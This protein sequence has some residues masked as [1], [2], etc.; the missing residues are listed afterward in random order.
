[1]GSDKYSDSTMV[2]QLF[3]RIFPTASLRARHEGAHL[4]VTNTEL[5][6]DLVYVFAIIQL[7]H[8]L[9]AHPT[10]LGALEAVTLFAAI[11]WA[12]NYT[13]WAANW[14]D[15][16][17]PAGRI[18]MLVLMACALLMAIS[19]ESAFEYR[20]WLFVSAYIAMALVRAGYMAGVLRGQTMGRNYAQLGAWSAFS[21]LFWIAG[22]HLPSARIELWILA[23]LIDYAAPYV[24]FWLPGA[25]HTPM[26]T[27]TLRGLHLLERNQL[28]FIIALGESI[29]MLGATM[30]EAELTSAAITAAAT[31]FLTIV[32]V[33]W[34]YFVHSASSGEEA[35]EHEA[36]QTRL[37]RASL[38]YA[39]G[40]M[41]GGAIV[42]A[43]SIEEIIA[44]PLEPA[45]IPTILAA[46][47]GPS[48]FLLGNALF[49]CSTAGR[50]PLSYVLAIAVLAAIGLAAHLLHI[51]ALALGCLVLVVL[52]G[53]AFLPSC[54]RRK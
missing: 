2:A 48:I 40:I 23:V 18:L 52:L 35:F 36:E 49:R 28:V 29:L 7:S 12:W 5:F 54:G 30:V 34:I 14:F 4:R 45:H 16:D 33:W 26:A 6:F 3:D 27:W 8:Y 20:A 11:W 39:H 38:A 43:V 41:V 46:V 44:H 17:H 1:V 47:L 37:A 19:I 25:G 42:I 50:W 32:S 31:G 10:W 51:P 21:G 53:L 24:G 22:A 15:P 13:A 9:V